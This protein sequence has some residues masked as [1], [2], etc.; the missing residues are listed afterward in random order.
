MSTLSFVNAVFGWAGAEAA[1]AS[2]RVQGA[3]H[4]CYLR[5]R[6][7]RQAPP[8]DVVAILILE[9]CCLFE[10][11]PFL[12][13]CA[14]LCLFALYG[15]LRTSDCNRVSHGQIMG[16]YF[17]GN[18]C[19]VKTARTLEKQTRFL[20]L[21]IPTKGLLGVSWMD[22]FIEARNILGLDGIPAAAPQ[23]TENEFILFPSQASLAYL[24]LERIGAAE[25]TERLGECLVQAAACTV[26]QA[27]HIP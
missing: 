22:S 7:L 16:N 23:T 25:V 17:E 19:K 18:L 27:V 21:I 12:R 8:L 26:L 5:K 6:V 10:P 3:A 2:Q 15:R 14:G 13:G 20:P 9:L 4:R 24:E 11:N 1:A